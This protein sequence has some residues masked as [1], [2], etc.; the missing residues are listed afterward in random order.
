MQRRMNNH[1]LNRQA[2]TLVELLVVISIIA[3]LVA[4][5]LPAVQGAREAARVTQCS[6]QLRQVA[7][8][9]L[10][11]ESAHGFMPSNGWGWSLVGDPN[12]GF[13]REQPG[14]LPSHP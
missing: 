7:V 13:G 2:F 1:I 9:S 6:N 8:A 14:G 11:H 10:T 12:Y 5:L 3:M 4:L